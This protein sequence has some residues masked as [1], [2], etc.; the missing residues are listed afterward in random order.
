MFL[1]YHSDRCNTSET[2]F[3]WCY[4]N[5]LHTTHAVVCWVTTRRPSSYC[6]GP[7]VQGRLLT[8]HSGGDHGSEEGLRQGFPSPTG[9]QEELLDPPDLA[10]TTAAACSMFR[11]KAICPIGFSRRGEYI[12][13]RGCQRVYQL[14]SPP[15]GAARGWAAPP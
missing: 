7:V 2:V 1:L 6:Y 11:G 8:H 14:V 9:C 12:G 13:E 10:T 4:V 5:D 3:H 15:G